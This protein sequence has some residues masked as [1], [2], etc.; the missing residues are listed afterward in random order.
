MLFWFLFAFWFGSCLFCFTNSLTPS[1]FTQKLWSFSCLSGK[2]LNLRVDLRL[3]APSL[4]YPSSMSCNFACLGGYT[5][6]S[7]FGYMGALTRKRSTVH[8]Y[9]TFLKMMMDDVKLRNIT[10]CH[11][12]LSLYII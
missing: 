11:F 10:L 5:A 1:S 12:P 9:T 2:A 4:A 3:V 6:G 8:K 7:S